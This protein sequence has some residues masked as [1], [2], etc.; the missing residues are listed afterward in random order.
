MDKAAVFI[1]GGYLA[2]VLKDFG[3]P[4]IDFLKMSDLFC[5]KA[6]AERF[7][8]YYY[9]CMPYQSAQP[10][11][12]ERERFMRTD[13]FINYLR[14]LPRFEIRLGKLGKREYVCTKCKFQTTDYEQKRVDNLLTVDLVSL[15]WQRVIQKAILLTGDSD[16][17]PAVQEAK[18][19]GVLAM[20]WY[21][22]TQNCTVHDELYDECDERFELDKKTI[23]TLTGA[24]RTALKLKQ[25]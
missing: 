22:R 8:T 18:K 11:P 2:K 25:A 19:A 4:R 24:T 1:D 7:R 23:D 6:N 10:T 5:A 21:A 3:E 9:F 20:V 13:K 12:E 17:V 15:S 16:F 14:R